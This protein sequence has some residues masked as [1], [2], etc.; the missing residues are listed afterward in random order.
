MQ[1]L[2]V[3]LSFVFALFLLLP[4]GICKS[5][6]YDY[7]KVD[8]YLQ[9]NGSVY[10]KQE[11]DYNF[12]GSFTYAYIDFLKKGS[13]EITILNIVDLD[14]GIQPIY[15]IDDNSESVKVTWY[16]S[17]NYEVKKFLI[18]YVIKDA[19]KKYDDVAEFY[20]KMIEQFMQ[21]N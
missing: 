17:S 11:R 15:E 13:N 5:Y 18:E 14:S 19:V 21:S 12:D 3:V 2:F 4:T 7:V 10:V 8:V 9:E 1:K 16:Y 6:H 20:W